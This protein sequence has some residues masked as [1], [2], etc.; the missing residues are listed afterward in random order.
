VRKQ[1]GRRRLRAA[2]FQSPT[3][4]R[5]RQP[6][7]AF[8]A[9]PASPSINLLQ[10]TSNTYCSRFQSAYFREKDSA[11]EVAIEWNVNAL[12]VPSPFEAGDRKKLRPTILVYFDAEEHFS[13]HKPT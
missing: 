5:L 12:R 11:A 6:E 1:E 4:L 10:L 2:G 7:F 13:E 9:T 8:H 3:Q